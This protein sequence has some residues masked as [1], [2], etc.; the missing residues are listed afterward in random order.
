[1]KNLCDKSFLLTAIA[2]LSFFSPLL[3][4]TTPEEFKA[5]HWDKSFQGRQLDLS[6]YKPTFIDHFDKM[7]ITAEGGTGPWF[8]PG[9]STFGAGKFLP[10]G[11]NGPFFIQNGNLILR[12]DK[13]VN[14]DGNFKWTAACMQ[15]VDPTTGHG[16]AQQYGYFEMKAKFPSGTGGWPA[17]WL[18]SQNGYLDKTKPRGEIDIV[19]WYGGDAKGIHTTGH[20]WPAAE[21]KPEDPVQKEIGSGLYT[22]IGSLLKDGKLEGFHTY[23]AELTPEW[24]IYYF[25]RQEVGRFPMVPEWRTPFYMLVDLAIFDEQAWESQGPKEMTV[26]YVMA[27][28]LDS[29][30][31]EKVTPS[32]VRKR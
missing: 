18:L 10:P 1:M 30:I 29:T 5:L 31:P 21:R 14:P 4:Q 19:E 26:E 24:V 32:P 27:Y 11:T 25:D 12:A 28:A 9:H 15:T 20:I 2:L 6:R 22:N 17:L 3:A 7:D 23:G 13:T 16:F 8:A